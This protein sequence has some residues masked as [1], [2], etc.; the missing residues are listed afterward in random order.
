[1]RSAAISNDKKSRNMNI[2]YSWTTDKH[3]KFQ[4][5]KRTKGVS[6][7]ND[8][9]ERRALRAPE[10]PP[11]GRNNF[12]SVSHRA[13]YRGFTDYGLRVGATFHEKGYTAFS[14]DKSVA[15]NFSLKESLMVLPLKKVA[16][17]T[18]WLWFG[19]KSLSEG[20][21]NSIH[22]SEKEVLLPPGKFRI[23]SRRQV[24]CL[25]NNNYD[26]N[27]YTCG[28]TEYQVS[29]TPD[30]KTPRRPNLLQKSSLK[31]AAT[32]IKKSAT[33]V[34]KSAT[35]TKKSATPTKKYATPTKTIR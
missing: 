35:P 34:K 30:Q 2:A 3:S 33:P 32:P 5:Q 31:S 16:P 15:Q 13:L 24:G 6:K 28:Y 25:P 23:I 18:P 26:N 29:F 22:P 4:E 27:D 8:V 11:G 10:I 21:F 9:F 12:D 20:W 14:R 1:M 19:K 7:L 17:G